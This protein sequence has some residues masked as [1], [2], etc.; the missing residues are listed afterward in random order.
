LHTFT[1]SG[2]W[3]IIPQNTLSGTAYY[4]YYTQSS[5]TLYWTFGIADTGSLSYATT[6]SFAANAAALTYTTLANVTSTP[7]GYNPGFPNWTSLGTVA[8]NTIV[9]FQVNMS[10][11][12]L[13]TQGMTFAI[14][15]AASNSSVVVS[16]AS[17]QNNGYGYPKYSYILTTGAWGNVNGTYIAPTSVGFTLSASPNGNTIIP[18]TANITGNAVYASIWNSSNSNI[19][20]QLYDVAWDGNQT[21]VA[22]GDAGYIQRSVG[23]PVSGFNDIQV[24]NGAA[25]LQLPN[26]IVMYNSSSNSTIP[27]VTSGTFQSLGVLPTGYGDT[28]WIKT[29]N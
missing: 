10:V 19:I 21:Y 23:N 4:P 20:A 3:N 1:S 6:T 7:T 26:T 27:V 28:L 18:T 12:T 2:T 25:I 16:S 29:S 13:G 22:V 8:A 14:S 5:Q 15:T 17:L 11:A 9:W 24:A